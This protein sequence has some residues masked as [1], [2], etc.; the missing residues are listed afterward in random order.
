[1]KELLDYLESVAYSVTVCDK[2]GIIVCQNGGSIKRK[3]YL[4]G[5]SVYDCHKP[6]SCDLIRRMLEQGTEHTYEFV[7]GGVRTL[8]HQTPWY[9]KHGE[10][11]GLIE[12]LINLPSDYPVFHR[13]E[14]AASG[15]K[16]EGE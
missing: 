2:E 16:G 10:V 4:V 6:H 5:K 14:P 11:A 12:I 1:M 15:S 13:D 7:K 3:G 8:A 9:D